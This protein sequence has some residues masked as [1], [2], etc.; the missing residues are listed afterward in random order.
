MNKEVLK[1]KTAV[2]QEVADE[3]KNSQAFVVCEYSKLTVKEISELRKAL[4]EKEAKASVYKNTLVNRALGT[5][6]KELV[7]LFSGSNMY[8]F[9]KDGTNG[10]L[11]LIAKFAKRHESFKIKG[12]TI[13]G[14]VA[15]AK[16]ITAIA[17]LPSKEGLVS[18]LLSVLQAPMRNLAYSLGQVAEKLP[19]AATAPAQ[20][21]SAEA[22]K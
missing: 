11:S 12:G 21:A 6:Y 2:V 18:M 19:A 9:C 15:D 22:A 1:A 7:E 17:L 16:Y 3:L 4:R 5:E 10:S 8:F 13:D 14:K 20:T